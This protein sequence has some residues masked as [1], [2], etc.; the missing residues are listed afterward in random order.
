MW[1]DDAE[2]GTPGPWVAPDS[3]PGCPSNGRSNAGVRSISEFDRIFAETEDEEEAE[4]GSWVCGI[5]GRLGELEHADARRIARV[6][7]YEEA[8]RAA[9]ALADM[10]EDCCHPARPT[11]VEITAFREAMKKLDA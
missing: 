10:A 9:E 8:L 7:A 11:P 4:D 2:K 3:G 5:W 6:P 1:K